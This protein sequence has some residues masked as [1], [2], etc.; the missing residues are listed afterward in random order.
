M[1]FT[2]IENKLVGKHNSN[3]RCEDAIVWNKRYACV[4]DGVTSKVD[5]NIIDTPT[6]GKIATIIIANTVEQL[7]TPVSLEEFIVIINEAFQNYYQTKGVASFMKANPTY[8]PSASVAI[9]NDYLKEVWLIGDC[10]AIVDGHTHTNHKEIDDLL[11][12]M[13][14]F[15]IEKELADGK[16]IE[17]LIRND[18]S[19]EKI[20]PF[21]I[22]QYT[23][24]NN[25]LSEKFSYGVIDGFQI[26]DKSIKRIKVTDKEVILATDGYP[27]IY[28]TLDQSENEL[29]QLLEKDPLCYNIHKSTKGIQGEQLSFDDRAY[30]RI[31]INNQ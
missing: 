18:T 31:E 4:I 19:R 7:D 21:L 16:S 6:S 29:A 12:Q 2:I 22:D 8:R 5:N 20:L 25:R 26:N 10:H 13:R 27:Y 17:D 1:S 11:S 14:S 15:L 9:Y 28:E 23:F 30:L 24:Q 3:E